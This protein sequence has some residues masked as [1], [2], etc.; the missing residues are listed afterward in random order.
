MD[1]GIRTKMADTLLQNSKHLRVTRCPDTDAAR[2][3]VEARARAAAVRGD[4]PA[5]TCLLTMLACVLPD[6]ARHGFSRGVVM[7]A[8]LDAFE[9]S[10]VHDEPTTTAAFADSSFPVWSKLVD[11]YSNRTS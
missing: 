11:S 5:A 10:V 1:D 9:C 3:A 6:P 2:L 8:H 4:T 7:Q